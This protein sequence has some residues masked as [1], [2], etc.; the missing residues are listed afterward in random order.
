MDDV[1]HRVAEAFAGAADPA[2]AAGAAAYM[3]HRFVF[4][5]I[6]APTQRALARAALAGLPA[7]TPDEVVRVASAAWE[8]PEREYQ[9][10]ACDWLRR[11]GKRCGPELL[12]V[13]RRLITT[14]SWWDTV[15][16]LATRVTGEL[17]SRH[18]DLATTMDAWITEDD[19]W[20]VRTALLHQL[21]YGAA[22]DPDRL[23]GYCTR[24]AGHPDF[25]VRKAIGWALRQYARTDPDAVRTYLATHDLSPLSRREAAKHL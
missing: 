2:R 5:G 9:Y 20:L 17:V 18:P 6:P 13:L 19:L 7:P 21:N 11:H 1:V 8:L 14:K 24:Q 25:F 16:P 23:L 10:F 22:T 15:D 3:R 12:P 4:L